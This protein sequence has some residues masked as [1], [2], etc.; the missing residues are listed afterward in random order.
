MKRDSISKCTSWLNMIDVS[1]YGSHAMHASGFQSNDLG[2]DG[3]PYLSSNHHHHHY[4]H[5]RQTTSTTDCSNPPESTPFASQSVSNTSS[6][7]VNC[8]PN[9]VPQQYSHSHLYSPSAIEYGITTSNSPSDLYF[10]S[11]TQNMFYNNSQLTSGPFQQTRIISADNGLSYTNLDYMY[12]QQQQDCGD[13]LTSQEN[14]LHLRYGSFSGI[15]TLSE[16]SSDHQLHH[17]IPNT[18][19]PH[20]LYTENSLN[21][22]QSNCSSGFSTSGTLDPQAL[23]SARLEIDAKI[24]TVGSSTVTVNAGENSHALLPLRQD[25]VQ[26]QNQQG[27]PTYKWM[28]VKRNVPKPQSK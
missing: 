25:H 27:A 8:S 4:Y 16:N 5:Q 13:S 9:S 14:K 26:Q 21:H 2:S 10:D 24:C 7:V 12:S 20:H 22:A 6:A 18:S 28:Q 15:S 23:N 3:Y 1:V 17:S 11:E 19:W